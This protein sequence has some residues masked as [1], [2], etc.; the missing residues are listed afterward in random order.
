MN[1]QRY[2]LKPLSPMMTIPEAAEALGM[3][4]QTALRQV[5]ATG[6]LCGIPAI[7]TSR[8]RR[9]LNRAAVEA[10]AATNA[11]VRR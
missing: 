7:Q 9:S 4:R 2:A 11:T 5:K 10:L 3:H 8:T 6:M 1:R